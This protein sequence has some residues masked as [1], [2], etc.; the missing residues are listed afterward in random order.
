MKFLSI[1][2]NV[3]IRKDEIIAVER[4]DIG[5]ARVVTNNGVY[6]TDFPYE[7][8]LQ[9]LEVPNIEERLSENMTRAE[10]FHKPQQYWAG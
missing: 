7:T 2:E 8:I 1:N 4:D 3:S 6:S 5:L 10:A 9:L